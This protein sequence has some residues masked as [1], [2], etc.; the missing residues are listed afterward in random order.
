MYF[1]NYLDECMVTGCLLQSAADEKGPFVSVCLEKVCHR[2]VAFA[3][4]GY[5]R[6]AL[7]GEADWNRRDDFSQPVGCRYTASWVGYCGTAG[8]D[9]LIG[10]NVSEGG[11]F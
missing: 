1:Q 6:Y 2:C 11:F 8:F 9:Y 4:L 10:C 7:T 5:Y 3:E